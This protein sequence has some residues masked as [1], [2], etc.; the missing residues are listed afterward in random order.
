MFFSP[1]GTLI[2]FYVHAP[3]L[4]SS[5]FRL[6]LQ[7]EEHNHNNKSTNRKCQNQFIWTGNDSNRSTVSDMQ[8]QERII[9]CELV[10]IKMPI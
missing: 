9:N 3:L 7:C 1:L 5:T 6:G 4:D 10:L 2:Y 8:V